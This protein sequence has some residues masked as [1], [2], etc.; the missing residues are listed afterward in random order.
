MTRA[1][2]ILQELSQKQNSKEKHS[3]MPGSSSGL[4]SV[5]CLNKFINAYK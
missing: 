2:G 5:C 1:G 3:T 4:S